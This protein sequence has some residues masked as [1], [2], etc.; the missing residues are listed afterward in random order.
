MKKSVQ[1]KNPLVEFAYEHMQ[2]SLREHLWNRKFIDYEGAFQYSNLF[3]SLYNKY[4]EGQ[5][6][7][8]ELL[9]QFPTFA[10]LGISPKQLYMLLVE[11][12]STRIQMSFD[13]FDAEQSINPSEYNVWTK[14]LQSLILLLNDNENKKLVNCLISNIPLASTRYYHRLMQSVV[15]LPTVGGNEK[16][17]TLY[18]PLHYTKSFSDLVGSMNYDLDYMAIGRF[19]RDGNW[20]KCLTFYRE[21]YPYANTLRDLSVEHNRRHRKFVMLLQNN[22]NKGVPTGVEDP[23]EKDWYGYLRVAVIDFEEK[24]IIVYDPLQ[25]YALADYD[26]DIEKYKMCVARHVVLHISV[27]VTSYFRLTVDSAI[28]ETVSSMLSEKRSWSWNFLECPQGGILLD[29][30]ARALKVY[31]YRYHLSH[32]VFPPL[33]MYLLAIYNNIDLHD[34]NL[35]PDELWI[36]RKHVIELLL[37]RKLV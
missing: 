5:C 22:I 2:K 19:H 26:N 35:T 23:D 3:R 11:S 32:I 8:D 10:D 16:K 12:S 14:L 1:K 20:L 15:T 37:T 24:K 7:L 4:V 34:V 27:I 25:S 29:Q 28:S 18:I 21:Q 31:R 6:Q 13:L 17:H 30:D 9:S 33:C 36:F